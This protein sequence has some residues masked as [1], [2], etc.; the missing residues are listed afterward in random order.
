MIGTES[1]IAMGGGG[2]FGIE[3]NDEF[4][5]SCGENATFEGGALTD[6]P[7]FDCVN[8]EVWS[9]TM[10]DEPDSKHQAKR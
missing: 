4:R 5:G 6:P 2:H 7:S 3:I 8:L 1:Y 9:F 10:N